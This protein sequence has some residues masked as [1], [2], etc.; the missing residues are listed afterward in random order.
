MKQPL[1]DKSMVLFEPDA[2]T[3]AVLRDVLRNLALWMRIWGIHLRSTLHYSGAWV[4]AERK[5]YRKKKRL[6]FIDTHFDKAVH[7]TLSKPLVSLDQKRA[8]VYGMRYSVQGAI[9]EQSVES[10]LKALSDDYILINNFVHI[11]KSPLF[12]TKRD[13]IKSVQIDHI[14]VGPPGVFLIETYGAQCSVSR[15]QRF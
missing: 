6:K 2:E 4:N 10:V 13:K 12:Y 9:G 15:S 8:I 1:Y 3:K 5:L 11:F 7:Q 14:L